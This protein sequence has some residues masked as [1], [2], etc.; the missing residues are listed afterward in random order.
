MHR[1]LCKKKTYGSKGC[2][3]FFLLSSD[4]WFTVHCR[5]CVLTGRPFNQPVR[6]DIQPASHSSMEKREKIF[7]SPST[8]IHFILLRVA[9]LSSKQHIRHWYSCRN[10][11]GI[12]LTGK[13]FSQ[14]G[15][16]ARFN[17]LHLEGGKN[18]WPNLFTDLCW[19]S[20]YVD[21]KYK[22]CRLNVFCSPFSKILLKL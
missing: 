6:T 5:R 2:Y 11:L 18:T 15:L 7:S 9:L 8:W 17:W 14:T 19:I 12:C 20:G 4:L 3:Y 1:E 21:T 22:R 16:W 13:Q 10:L